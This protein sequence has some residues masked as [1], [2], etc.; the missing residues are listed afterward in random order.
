M[1]DHTYLFSGLRNA[2]R[3]LKKDMSAIVDAFMPM[4][5]GEWNLH[6]IVFHMRD[7]NAEVYLPRLKRIVEEWNPTF[8]NFDGKQWMA[9]HYDAGENLDDMV[10]ELATQCVET[11]DWLESLPET[12]WERLG[13]HPSLGTH[14]LEWWADRTLKH[15]EEHLAQVREE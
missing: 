4:K 13:T 6:Q 11:A 9:T 5:P 2:P 12:D 3:Q 7:V 10:D 14:A 8:E 15:I 1:D